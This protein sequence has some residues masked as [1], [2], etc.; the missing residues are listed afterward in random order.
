MAM[1]RQDS[2]G[3][4]QSRIRAINNRLKAY[5][6]ARDEVR[7]RTSYLGADGGAVTLMLE[8]MLRSLVFF[9]DH[10]PLFE[11]CCGKAV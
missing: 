10:A 6:R 3:S 11:C 8:C 4:V 9:S 5:S 2:K 7:W 1:G